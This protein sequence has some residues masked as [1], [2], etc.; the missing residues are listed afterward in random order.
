MTD[1]SKVSKVIDRNGHSY[2]LGRL[3][4]R[5]GQGAVYSVKGSRLAV[6]LVAKQSAKRRDRMRNQLM[7][8]RRLPLKGVN[9]AKPLETLRPPHTGYVMELLTDMCPIKRLAVPQKGGSFSVDWYKA[10]GGLGRRLQLLART[11]YTLSQLHGNGLAY[12]DPSPDNIYISDDIDEYEVWLI[13]A[14][15]LCYASSPDKLSRNIYTPGFGAPELVQGK[16]G[17]STLTDVYSFAVIAFQVLTGTHP[18]IGDVVNDGEPEME[19]D[20][21]NGKLPWIEDP[22]DDQN[23][24][25]F[26]IPR[27]WVLSKN[28]RSIF[29]KTFGPGRLDPMRRP[30]IS[31]WSERLYSAAD[32]AIKCSN[33]GQSFFVGNKTCPWCN[34]PRPAFLF[35]EV[36]LWDPKLGAAGELV[37]RPVEGVSRPVIVGRQFISEGNYGNISRRL[38][39]GFMDAQMDKPAATIKLIGKQIKITGYDNVKAVLRDPSGLNETDISEDGVTI[40][41][42]NSKVPWQLHM[43]DVDGLHRVIKFRIRGGDAA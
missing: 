30:G 12:S 8:V 11:S 36:N 33:C 25:S 37:S 42:E 24:A 1:M 39:H 32:A 35:L 27:E 9:L 7:F 23:R 34:E 41:A 28:L 14:D 10:G 22:V 17:V 19:D 16:A 15:N 26:G 40:A 20:A 31:E 13:D 6:K 5:G 2:E 4:G 18:F 43:G 29:N 38:S 3:L 21:F